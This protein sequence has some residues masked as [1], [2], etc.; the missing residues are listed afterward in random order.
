MI[1]IIIY[2]FFIDF[3]SFLTYFTTKQWLFPLKTAE[4]CDNLSSKQL[5]V[6]NWKMMKKT[7]LTAVVTISVAVPIYK[8]IN[9]SNQLE[10][11]ESEN[12]KLE[13]SNN[14]IEQENSILSE[15]NIIL[16]NHIETTG[17]KNE[18]TYNYNDITKVS[19]VTKEQLRYALSESKLF[20]YIDEFVEVEIKYGVNALFM[21][22]LVA[23]ESAWLTSNRTLNQNNVTGYAVYSDSAKG[24]DFASIEE[25][26]LKTGELLYNDYIKPESKH[27][28]GLSVEDINTMYSADEDWDKIIDSI[29]NNLKDK[30]NNFSELIYE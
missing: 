15:H 24:K 27:Y 2:W 21:I 10:V 16:K 7:L 5:K 29:A 1:F 8:N 22:G 14:K 4:T 23:N 3:S 26:I 6:G 20:N 13:S 18:V 28:N 30:I 9:L 17:F 19:N 12:K 11:I 25:S